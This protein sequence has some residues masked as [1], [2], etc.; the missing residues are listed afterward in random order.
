MSVDLTLAIKVTPTAPKP[1]VHLKGQLGGPNSNHWE[2]VTLERCV[3]ILTAGYPISKI[4]PNGDKTPLTVEG[5]LTP[6]S[7]E[8]LLAGSVEGKMVKD[9]QLIEEVVEEVTPTAEPK[10]E[11]K[12]KPKK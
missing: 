1:Y 9:G 6:T 4:E 12:E 2:Y 10:V 3:A 7:P 8:T 5:I 11:T